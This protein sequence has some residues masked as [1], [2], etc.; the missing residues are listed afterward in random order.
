MTSASSTRYV[1]ASSGTSVDGLDIAIVEVTVESVQIVSG[2]TVPFAPSLRRQLLSLGA[3]EV[4]DIDS[5][6]ATDALLGRF[7]G[8]SINTCLASNGIDSASI[9][10]IGSHGQ[11]VRHRSRADPPFTIQIGDP[12]LIAE[13]T[14]ITTVADFRRRD[15]AAGGEG[16]P[17]VP[18]FHN[19]LFGS[20]SDEPRSVLNIGGMANITSLPTSPTTPIEGFDTGPGNT[21]LD[22]WARANV[23]QPFDRDGEWS[24]KGNLI[25]PL[26][27]AFMRD[28]YFAQSPP[29]STGREAFSLDWLH[30]HLS[31]LA[32]PPKAEDVQST[33]AELT[34]RSIADG[35]NRW[36]H[37]SGLLIVAGGGRLNRELMSRIQRL[38][39]N[40]RVQPSDQLGVNGDWL[41]AAAFA[42]LAHRTLE[43]LAG[44]AP[45]VTGARA[46]RVLGAIYPGNRPG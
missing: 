26:L 46:A 2:R 22:A 34:A 16:A 35:L 29:K 33:L 17:L 30:R 42:W 44:N 31:C 3:A 23:G 37:A 9:R 24:T 11:T 19:A 20:G 27:D 32:A 6:G 21:L 28:P 40:H 8:N 12:N 36:G 39:P 1:G 14:G 15:I 5:L 18:L 41:E 7:I 38:L 4:D 43:G 13:L 45:A 25:E 10:A